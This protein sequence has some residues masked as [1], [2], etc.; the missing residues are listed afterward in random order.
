[1]NQYPTPGVYLAIVRRADAIVAAGGKVRTFWCNAELD[2]AGWQL[3][4]MKALNR[5]INAKGGIDV[6]NDSDY[7]AALYRDKRAG[8]D[9]RLRRIV[10]RG[11]GMET[12]LGRSLYPDAHAAMTEP[13]SDR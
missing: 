1:M 12:A 6:P 9:Y 13:W 10:R 4:K 11:S 8:E 2:A 7:E 5:R 3:E